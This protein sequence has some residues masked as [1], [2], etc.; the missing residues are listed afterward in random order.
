MWLTGRALYPHEALQ[1]G[2]ITTLQVAFV[3]SYLMVTLYSALM[4]Y[5]LFINPQSV[6]RLLMRL[7]STSS[8]C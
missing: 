2:F 4:L 1:G 6:K 3:L 5:A 7:F 8:E